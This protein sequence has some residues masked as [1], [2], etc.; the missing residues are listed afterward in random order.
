MV[1]PRF[2]TFSADQLCDVS[3]FTG[4]ASKPV[5]PDVSGPPRCL[6][7]DRRESTIMTAGTEPAVLPGRGDLIR[8]VPLNV[9]DETVRPLEGVAPAVSPH[10]GYRRGPLLDNV[11]VFTA[12]W[13]AASQDAPLS[14]LATNLMAS[15]TSC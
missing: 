8:I 4:H 11:E 1:S 15:S 13:G 9:P 14:D 10:A 3:T 12:F 6:C 2:D 7:C 5:R